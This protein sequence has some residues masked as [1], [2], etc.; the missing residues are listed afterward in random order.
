MSTLRPILLLV[1]DRNLVGERTLLQKVKMAVAGGVDWVQVRERNLAGTDLANHVRSIRAAA[2]EGASLRSGSV[3]ILVNRFV[4]VAISVGADGVHLGYDGMPSAV[5]RKIL[6]EDAVVTTSCHS[7]AEVLRK[8]D[9]AVDAVQFA[10]IFNP[11]SK[12]PERVPIELENLKKAA[13]AAPSLRIFAQG[14]ITPDNA[15]NCIQAGA[16]GIAVTGSL[17]LTKN[18]Q[19]R[20]EELRKALD[21][22]DSSH[23]L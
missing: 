4:D 17:L 15:G 2:K 6:P 11:I 14:G 16:R 1:T 21:N 7:V 9:E 20:A 8:K 3:K 23:G 10:P 19:R 22:A 13:N 18:S 5:A 12:Q